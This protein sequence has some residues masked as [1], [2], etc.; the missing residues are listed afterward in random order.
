MRRGRRSGHGLRQLPRRR[1]NIQLAEGRRL[2]RA[3]LKAANPFTTLPQAAVTASSAVV[4]KGAA[5]G[6]DHPAA[7]L[8]EKVLPEAAVSGEEV[9]AEAG[10]QRAVEAIPAG[11]P[12]RVGTTNRPLCGV[13]SSG[14]CIASDAW[15]YCLRS[16]PARPG[17]RPNTVPRTSGQARK[18]QETIIPA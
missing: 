6:A 13:N 11:L 12:Q 17:R 10:A 18:S 7:P 14:C 1:L 8:A 4:P 5:G 16:V 9:R 3:R 2:K 15:L